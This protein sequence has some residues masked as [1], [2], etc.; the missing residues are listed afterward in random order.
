M[1]VPRFS[2]LTHNSAVKFEI[3]NTLQINIFMWCM[4]LSL[5]GRRLPLWLNCILPSSGMLSS[6]GWFRTDLHCI[7]TQKTEEFE[8]F[9]VYYTLPDDGFL[10]DA[11]TCRNNFYITIP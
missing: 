3:P 2:S 1:I 4:C 10:K 9:L 11:E 6:V 5:R 8:P 7:I